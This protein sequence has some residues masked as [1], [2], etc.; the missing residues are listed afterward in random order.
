[1]Q[2]IMETL[3]D[4][5]YLTLVIT[6]G[7]RMIRGSQ[8]NGQFRLFGIMV[9]V[10]GAGRRIPFDS[11]SGCPVH[12]GLEHYIRCAGD[13]EVDYLHHHDDFLCTALLC[14]A[15]AVSYYG[16]AWFAPPLCMFWPVCGFFFA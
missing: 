4:V 11:T 9:V 10:L 15:A 8:G 14:V 1:M 12:H 2:A 3:F 7:L 13:G 5:V 16:K 6:I